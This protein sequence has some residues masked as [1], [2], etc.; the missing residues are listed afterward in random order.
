[1]MNF[2]AFKPFSQPSARP[3]MQNRSFRSSAFPFRPQGEKSAYTDKQ[4]RQ[5]HHIE[6][7]LEQKG[8]PHDQAIGIAWATVNKTYGG[9]LR[10][11]GSA[12]D[13]LK[14]EDPQRLQ[15]ELQD[16]NKVDR[17]QYVDTHPSGSDRHDNDDLKATSQPHHLALEEYIQNGGRIVSEH[18]NKRGEEYETVVIEMPDGRRQSFANVKRDTLEKFM[19]QQG[20]QQGN[21]GQQFSQ[22]QQM[23]RQQGGQQGN[24]GQQFSRQSQGGQQ[25][26]G[27]QYGHAFEDYMKN[28]GRI[29]SEHPNKRGDETVVVEMP[30]G[31]RQSFANINRQTL[32]FFMMGQN[33]GQQGGQQFNRQS[34]GGQ[35]RSQGSNMGNQGQQSFSNQGQGQQGNTR[36]QGQ[37]MASQAQGAQLKQGDINAANARSH[38]QQ[39]NQSQSS[40]DNT[41]FVPPQRQELHG[42]SF[43]NGQAIQGAPPVQHSQNYQGEGRQ[44]QTINDVQGGQQSNQ[45]QRSQGGQGNQRQY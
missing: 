23:N 1:M 16:D 13:K 34:Q 5:A 41:R 11:K 26:Q 27:Q 30:D 40:N 4:L 28:G 7:S 44:T 38:S 18:A 14:E 37:N 6:E 17:K 21:Q 43:Q 19:G 10:E 36:Q 20:G 42:K 3:M 9:G 2:R 33:Q 24:Q 12:Y 39:A 31:S 15:Q 32:E 29:V 8:V 22:G 35:N 25:N 45:G